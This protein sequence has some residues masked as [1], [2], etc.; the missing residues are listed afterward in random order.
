[1]D[2]LTPTTSTLS[3]AISHIA[4][5]AAILTTSLQ[6][7]SPKINPQSEGSI[8]NTSNTRQAQQDTVR[9]VIATPHR[10]RGLLDVGQVDEAKVDWLQVQE[11][12]RKWPG[13]KGVEQIEEECTTIIG[14]G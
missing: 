12:L 14:G 5:T 10:L 11:L 2:P 9:W 13:V 6:N 1:M 7:G 3:P 4:E 8:V